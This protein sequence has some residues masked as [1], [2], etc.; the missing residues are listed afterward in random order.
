LIVRRELP[1][2]EKTCP[3]EKVVAGKKKD[4]GRDGRSSSI[5]GKGQHGQEDGGE[6][7]T[8]PNPRQGGQPTEYNRL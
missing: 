4:H 8:M 1:E 6:R 3:T 5:P 7:K 2:G